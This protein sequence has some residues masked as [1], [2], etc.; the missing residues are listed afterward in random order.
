M[1][2]RSNEISLFLAF[3][4]EQYKQRHNLTGEQSMLTFNKYG[5]LNYLETNYEPLHSQSA[6]WILEDI[7]EFINN[8]KQ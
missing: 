3:C 8:R 2:T 1:S 6:Q 7:D 4:I 5:V